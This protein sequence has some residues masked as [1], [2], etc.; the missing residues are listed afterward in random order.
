[1]NTRS[2]SFRLITWYAGVLTTVFVLLGVLTFFILRH[3]L[4]A[5]LLDIQARRAQQIADTLVARASASGEEQIRTEVESLYSP[6]ANDRFIRISRGD[7]TV[8]YASGA[9]RSEAFD[10]RQ[11]QVAL[12]LN[13]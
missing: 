8:V 3:Y 1:M 9:P 5:N 10:P 2:L 4:E 7:G 13:W 11:L 12:K 6:E